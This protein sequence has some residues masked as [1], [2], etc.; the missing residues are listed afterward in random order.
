MPQQQNQQYIWDIEY[1]GYQFKFQGSQKPDETEV[2]KAYVD[3]IST[4]DQQ[5]EQ[6]YSAPLIDIGDI[7][8]EDARRKPIKFIRTPHFGIGLANHFLT[9][10]HLLNLNKHMKKQ[11]SRGR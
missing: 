2:H 3:Y 6:K 8:T 7:E 10:F 1:Q 5:P 9:H 11:M 4:L